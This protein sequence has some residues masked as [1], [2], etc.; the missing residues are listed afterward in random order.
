MTKLQAQLLDLLRNGPRPA[1][2]LAATL[3]LSVRGATNALTAMRGIGQVN[4]GNVYYQWSPFLGC[5]HRPDGPISWALGPARKVSGPC[6]VDQQT[7]L[8]NAEGSQ[9]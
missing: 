7:P 8:T 1:K 6:P 9:Q 4:D 5:A 2:E 3:G